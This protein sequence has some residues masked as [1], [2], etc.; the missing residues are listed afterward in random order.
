MTVMERCMKMEA[1]GTVVR[2]PTTSSSNT[3]VTT[4][5]YTLGENGSEICGSS[6]LIPRNFQK[7]S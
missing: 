3:G 6:S 4:I 1:K 5:P 2:A 7:L